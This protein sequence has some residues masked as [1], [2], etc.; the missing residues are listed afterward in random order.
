MQRV[1]NTG[2]TADRTVTAASLATGLAI[3]LFIYYP[4][5]LLDYLLNLLMLFTANMKL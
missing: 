5:N 2:Q 4:K 3:C 1:A